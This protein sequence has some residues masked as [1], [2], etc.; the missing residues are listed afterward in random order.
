M[1]IT[2]VTG[3]ANAG[4]AHVVL[5]AVRRHAAHGEEPLLV[6]PT[7]AD[8][9]RYR[10]E[11]ADGGLVMG[12][13]VE[14]FGGLIAEAVSR[15]VL[16][17]E[18]AR[19]SPLAREPLSPVLRER[20]LAALGARE[21]P[22][23]G[24]GP[25][26][27]RA[28]SA[29]VVEL[30]VARISP[31]RLNVAL[32]DWAAAEGSVQGPGGRLEGV[33]RVRRLA[34]LYE[35]YRAAL[36]E[37]GRL[38][39]ELR[40]TAALDELRRAPRLWRG[41]PALFY[42]FDDLTPLQL[43]ALET[44]GSVVGAS[45]TV[46]LAFEPGRTAFA[47]RASTFQALLPIAD[48]HRA[49][50]AQADHYSPG[51]RADLHHLEREL[52]EQSQSPRRRGAGAIQLLKGGGE[53][54]ELELVAAEIGAL[55]QRGFRPGEIAVV[56]RSPASIAALIGEVLGSFGI[57]FA[58]E[59][60]R[61]FG[62]TGLGRSLLGLLACAGGGDGGLVPGR[63]SDLLAWLRTPG[64]LAH[65]ELADR[66]E[67]EVRRRGVSSAA[68]ARALWEAERWPLEDIDRTRRAATSGP[69]A[70]IAHISRELTRLFAL[71]RR[72][73][74]S[75]L[76]DNELDEARALSAAQRALKELRELARSAPELLGGIG[77]VLHALQTL[78]IVSGD[79]SGPLTVAVLDPLALRA[80][81]VKALFLC[82]L[83]EGVFPAAAAP[84]PL[85]GEEERR[86]LNEASGLGLRARADQLAGE[87]YLMYA[88]VSRPE[89]L[90]VLSW[91]A[92]Q[93]DE[94]ASPRSLFVED[95][96]DLFEDGLGQ[97]RR[98]R[99]LGAA[100]W[101]GAG[102]PVLGWAERE[103]ALRLPARASEAIA[104]LSDP[105]LLSRLREDRLWSASSLETWASCPVRWL[106]ERLLAAKGLEP[107]P[108]PLARGALAHAALRDVFEGLR[109]QTGAA[110]LTP[111]RLELA[112][113]LLREALTEHAARYPLSVAPER[114]PGSMRRLELDLGRYLRHASQCE[115]RMEAVH[116]ELAFGFTELEEGLPALDLGDGIRLRGRIDRVDVGP[117]D[118]AVVYDYKGEYAP[119]AARWLGE[120]RFQLTLYMLAV[121]QL[122][123]HDVVGGL[124]Q[125]LRGRDLR[126]RGVLRSDVGV[127]GC[128]STDV[129][130]PEE[131]DVLLGESIAQAR[132]AAAEADVGALSPRP[133]S[134]GFGRS[135]CM[136]PTICRCER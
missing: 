102:E 69:L 58:L 124:Y 81:R 2:L 5:E 23:T 95:V 60:R 113:G 71:P 127:E 86:R 4:K 88:T 10:A 11:L 94:R 77:G 27:A 135:G 41:T 46:S 106:V 57:P 116:L 52:F 13:R 96:C 55:L 115:N 22:G 89:E 15:A 75:V 121:G 43:D 25:G 73:L 72:R 40:A 45:V 90:L 36:L 107:D 82:G 99:A 128:V 111:E 80:R 108:E 85:L 103:R 21:W 84:E 123:G 76:Q 29:F 62:H 37:I 122:L 109:R 3:P 61:L 67:A 130:E 79:P 119:A 131:F 117:G 136:Y 63:A 14:R 30:E 91:H 33:D 44:L 114:V 32:E 53:R 12:A 26:L 59:C 126:A 97:W 93:E 8:V 105:D 18:D 110:Q 35:R 66:L 74:A 54:A 38:D 120:Q 87:R 16:G 129:L 42:G 49:L 1:P 17:S 56:H 34:R 78:E 134:C 104:P 64:L 31:E 19:R 83:Q 51:A 70:L 9:E 6:V 98:E 133:E 112:L 47:G 65:P 68:D 24:V 7:R 48:E 50:A 39:P 92:S 28:L 20:M 100:G 132:Q 118:T 125:P 101:P